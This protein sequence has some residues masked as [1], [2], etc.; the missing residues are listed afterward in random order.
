MQKKIL[1]KLLKKTIR[2]KF[3]TDQDRRVKNILKIKKIKNL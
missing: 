3:K 1:Q 2:L